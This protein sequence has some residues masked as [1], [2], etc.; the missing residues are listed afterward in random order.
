V[1]GVV[2]QVAAEAPAAAVDEVADGEEILFVLD[3]DEE[4]DEEDDVLVVVQVGQGPRWP[5]PT[6]V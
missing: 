3:E 4:E 6:H 5:L 1:C 2:A